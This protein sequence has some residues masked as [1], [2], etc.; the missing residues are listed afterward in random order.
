MAGPPSLPS[1]STS[2]GQ[3]V[4]Y[5]ILWPSKETQELAVAVAPAAYVQRGGTS[6]ADVLAAGD[7]RDVY[8][9]A[10]VEESMGKKLP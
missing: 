2:C 8:M 4:N 3:D 6:L 10:P 9:R 1:N 7:R 5:P